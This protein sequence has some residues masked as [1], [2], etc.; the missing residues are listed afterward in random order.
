MTAPLL[1]LNAGSSSL[2]FALYRPSAGADPAPL[3]RGQFA[4]IGRAL[5][6]SAKSADGHPLPSP[7]AATLAAIRNHA[8]A[9][10]LLPD[11][12]ATNGLGQDLAGAGHRVVHGGT[13][14]A[15]PERITPE[16]LDALSALEPLAPH[17]QPHNVAAIRAL[18]AQ[19]PALPQVA[20][21]D[22]AF[23]AFMPATAR[24]LG[25]PAAYEAKGMRRYGFHGLS[26]EYVTGRLR[27][28]LG[29]T[30][31]K[32]LVI[33]HLGN[34]ASMAAVL[35]GKGHATTMGFSTLDG[36]VMGTRIGSLDPGAL[37]H[38]IREEKMDLKALEDLLYNKS[39]LL[40][41]SGFSADMKTLLE[42]PEPRAAAAIEQYC[43]AIV[44][45]TGSLAA[46]LGGLDALVFTG[47]VGENAAP[48]RARV[49]RDLAWLG[50]ELD[51]A[52]NAR[53]GPLLTRTKA[54]TAAY[55]VPTDEE[56]VIARHT[57]RLLEL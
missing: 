11:W 13:R 14:F 48:I 41:L 30:L 33:A 45:H 15:A 49:C 54:R 20:C 56:L 23:H 26:Y 18:M 3:A 24:S 10:L 42:S 2:K 27:Q 46:A 38:L 51:E 22:T 50:I 6:F 4:G 37:L 55:T 35:D 21:F 43:Y 57:A 36:I 25:L 7:D 1:I 47:G 44:R 12:L 5:A 8:D 16:I 28:L 9:L 17:H 32:R 40:G 31:P 53:G 39:G 34:G 52:A 29:G 19:H